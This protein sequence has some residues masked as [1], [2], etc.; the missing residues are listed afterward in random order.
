MWPPDH[1]ALLGLPRGI[2]DFA[3]IEARVLD[4]MELLRP[5][6]LLHPDAVTDGMNRLA[7]ALVCLTDPVAR[8]GYDRGLGIAPSPFE[9]VED[10]PLAEELWQQHEA[11]SPTEA[12]FGPGLSPPGAAPNPHYEVVETPAPLPYEVVPD[13]QLA[14]ELPPAYEVVP[15]APASP[16][17]R[18]T[19]IPPPIPIKP[20]TLYRRLIALRRAIRAWE[21][22]RAVMGDPAESLATPVAVLRFLRALA[23]ARRAIPAVACVLSAPH[24]PGGIVAALVRSPHAIHTVRTLQPSQ[25]Q[26]LARDWRR[27]YDALQRERNSLREH[28]IATRARR[29]ANTGSGLFIVLRRVPELAIVAL[30]LVVLFVALIRRNS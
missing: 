5:H 13:D 25:R 10:E 24:T 30:A 1:Y 18:P 8:A 20:R 22:L 26:A 29:R 23:D 14:E 12:P 15:D 9:V 17:P 2:G 7:Q 28:A 11:E 21:A 6:Q 3:E 19:S 27:G 4:R 16:K